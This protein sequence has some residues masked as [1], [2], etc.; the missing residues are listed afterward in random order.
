MWRFPVAMPDTFST[1][2]LLLNN[3]NKFKYIKHVTH[4]SFASI[5]FPLKNQL[6]GAVWSCNST[7]RTN[8][9]LS[10]AVV[11]FSFLLNRFWSKWE[12]KCRLRKSYKRINSPSCR[13][14]SLV[15]Q[16]FKKCLL[17]VLQ[18]KKLFQSY[19]NSLVT[20]VLGRYRYM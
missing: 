5:G 8:F 2:L 11:F 4:L 17:L 3:L 6:A 15:E 12:E 13:L 20:K 9:S 14:S 18:L 19:I 16:T 7:S 1:S 10:M